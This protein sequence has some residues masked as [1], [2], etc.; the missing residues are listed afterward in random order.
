MKTKQ[1]KSLIIT[2][3]LGLVLLFLTVQFVSASPEPG[4]AERRVVVAPPLSP[5]ESGLVAP[6]QQVGNLT[7][8]LRAASGLEI[9]FYPQNDDTKPV[10]LLPHLTLYQDGNLT[11]AISPRTLNITVENVKV[12]PG[13]TVTVE[14]TVQ[15]QHRDPDRGGYLTVPP[16]PPAPLVPVWHGIQTRTVDIS[17]PVPWLFDVDFTHTFTEEIWYNGVYTNTPTDYFQV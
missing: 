2:S 5:M 7:A 4:Q 11:S 8:T 13:I 17:E 1:V 6:L 12:P 10:R 16:T 9:D 14:I 15:T 3:T